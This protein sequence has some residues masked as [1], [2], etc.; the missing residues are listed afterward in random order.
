M[1]ANNSFIIIIITEWPLIC[2]SCYY[3]TEEDLLVYLSDV[4][5]L[6]LFFISLVL[7]FYVK[8]TSYFIGTGNGRCENSE[9]SLPLNLVQHLTNNMTS[10]VA[11]AYAGSRCRRTEAA[12]ISSCR[13]K[14][15]LCHWDWENYPLQMSTVRRHFTLT[16]YINSIRPKMR[17]GDPKNN[18]NSQ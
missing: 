10:L 5:F 2:S 15:V 11:G 1:F 6:F 16:F 9:F 4:L 18:N 17:D 12:D 3:N 13:D 7:L 8:R 14:W